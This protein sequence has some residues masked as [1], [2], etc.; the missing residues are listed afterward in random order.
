MMAIARVTCRD[1]SGSL[2]E[3][4]AKIADMS[5]S[6][7][8]LRL[9][10]QIPPGSDLKIHWYREQ[11]SAV[12]K[13]CRALD[14]EFV[15]GVHRAKPQSAS[16]LETPHP[17]APPPAR[18]AEFA[19]PSA[20]P[21]APMSAPIAKPVEIPAAT[22]SIVKSFA[23]APPAQVTITTQ[24]PPPRDERTIM[25]NKWLQIASRRQRVDSSAEPNSDAQSSDSS[26]P[27]SKFQSGSPARDSVSPQGDLLPIEDIYRAAGII[28][29]RMG[30]TIHKISDMLRSDHLRGLIDENKRASILMALDA[31]GVPVDEVLRDANLRQQAIITYESS[32]R[33]QFEDY[34]NRKARENENLQA[35]MNR[36]SAQFAERINRNLEEVEKE[37][38]LFCKWQSAAQQE[39]QRISEAADLCSKPLAISA[40]ANADSDAAADSKPTLRGA[41]AAG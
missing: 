33:R 18:A 16:A 35:E 41:A 6:G 31:A 11:F 20:T 8:C 36:I 30:Y 21:A 40:A 19:P 13:Y 25:Q 14:G 2:R 38:D 12:S 37:K 22:T 34:W 5:H 32:Q 4:A 17:V 27:L 3:L 15:V 24:S 29:P 1:H 10:S 7:A 26:S 23:S 28:S 9:K 39:V